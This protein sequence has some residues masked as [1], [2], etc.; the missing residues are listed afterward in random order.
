MQIH[1]RP[2]KHTQAAAHK[3]PLIR[4]TGIESLLKRDVRYGKKAAV[5]VCGETRLQLLSAIKHK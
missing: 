4:S 5:C 1:T 3:T 2:R